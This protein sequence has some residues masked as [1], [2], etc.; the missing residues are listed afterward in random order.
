MKKIGIIGSGMVAKTLGKGFIMHGYQVMISSRDTSK[1]S[2][3]KE[4]VGENSYTG[5]FEEDAKF[6]DILV[7]A[8]AGRVAVDAIEMAGPGN[9]A[10]KT[11]IDTT[12]P[13]DGAP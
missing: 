2:E 11:V 10:G 12:N 9:L 13:I 8:G 1:L 5:S 3:W 7:L 4:Q 6:G